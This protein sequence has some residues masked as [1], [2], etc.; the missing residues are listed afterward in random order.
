MNKWLSLTCS[1]KGLPSSHAAF[2]FFWCESLSVVLVLMCSLFLVSEGQLQLACQI[3]Q[4]SKG[5]VHCLRGPLI[6]PKTLISTSVKDDAHQPLNSNEH[7]PNKDQNNNENSILVNGDPPCYLSLS[8]PNT[9]LHLQKPLQAPFKD[10]LHPFFKLPGEWILISGGNPI[11]FPRQTL[12]SQEAYPHL[13]KMLPL[14]M[15]Q[16]APWP[17]GERKHAAGLDKG[18]LNAPPHHLIYRHNHEAGPQPSLSTSWGQG[19]TT[20]EGLHSESPN[21]TAPWRSWEV[22]NVKQHISMLMTG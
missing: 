13:K 18:D 15:T 10:N 5:L 21:T 4:H 12:K 17:E 2:Y 11:R 1:P 14:V 9:T 3:P 20:A 8:T 6:P 16:S 7:S 22:T 19:G